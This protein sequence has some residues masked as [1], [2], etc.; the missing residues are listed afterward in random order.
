MFLRLL[1]L[2]VISTFLQAQ[3]NLIIYNSN[4]KAFYLT[5][6]KIEVT[7]T[8]AVEYNF[9]NLL[10]DTIDLHITSINK[11]IQL[12]S[13]AFLLVKGAKTTN[14]TFIYALETDTVKSK[15]YLRFLGI[16]DSPKLPN[17]LVPDVPYID[18]SYKM[19]NK[20]YG[21]IFEL[22]DGKPLF[23]NNLPKSKKCATPT[24]D[25]NISHVLNLNKKTNVKT[26]RVKFSLETVNNNCVTCAQVALL[27]KTVDF[28]LDRIKVI[29]EAFKNI[30]DPE[31]KKILEESVTFE[32]GKKEI[33]ESLALKSQ[34]QIKNNKVCAIAVPDSI[35]K[36]LYD[37][38]KLYNNDFD[39]VV[40]LKS[41]DKNNCYTSIQLKSLL[42]TFL[43]DREKL[44]VCKLYYYNIVDKE[45]LENYNDVFSFNETY[46]KYLDFLKQPE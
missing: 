10:F 13:T 41:I 3:N 31:N 7:E 36:S 27:C 35:V 1:A 15:F 12:S 33:R 23:F 18:T 43:H 26:D 30:T 37:N 5:S 6:K 24:S 40:Y 34:N 20:L 32:S 21:D 14:K 39:R 19:L 9:S 29:K 8:P 38:L 17:P 11:N 25:N 16:K 45:N 28:E 42:N 46:N 22:K 44:E 2:L 4:G